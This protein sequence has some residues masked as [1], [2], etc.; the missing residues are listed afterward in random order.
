MDIKT[1]A[2][3]GDSISNGA[4]DSEGGWLIRLLRLL[5]KGKS[6]TLYTLN[7]FSISGDLIGDAWHNLC[8]NCIHR[9]TDYLFIYIGANDIRRWNAPDAPTCSSYEAQLLYWDNILD[10]AQQAP[11]KVVIFGLLPL[12][13]SKGPYM[14]ES[15]TYYWDNTD[16]RSYNKQIKT[17]AAKRNIT[18]INW[19]D[20]FGTQ[21][22]IPDLMADIVHP[23]E[24]GHNRMANIAYQALQDVL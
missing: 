21:N 9:Q 24:A 14:C 1:I 17:W 22:N 4:C 20:E 3:V 8:R 23:N 5:N 11:Q 15:G 6:D 7:N 2:A 12:D 10:W 13:E 18:F 19:L 16:L